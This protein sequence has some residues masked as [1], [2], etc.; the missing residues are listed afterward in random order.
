MLQC[1]EFTFV[2]FCFFFSG[3]FFLIKSCQQYHRL[4]GLS[5]WAT[6][7]KNKQTNKKVILVKN[8]QNVLFFLFVSFL[9]TV[10]V[11]SSISLSLFFLLVL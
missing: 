10:V 6:H 3:R 5:L 11:D 8:H 4:T 1:K 2:F 7:A 9:S